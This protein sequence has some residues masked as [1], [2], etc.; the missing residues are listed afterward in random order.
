MRA[1]RLVSMLMILQARGRLTAQELAR[2]LEVSERT[3]YRDITAL[4]TAGVPIYAERGPGGGIALVERYR[5]NLTGLNKDEVQ[6][7]FMLSVPTAL[8]DLGLD[9]DLKTALRKLAA[10]LPDS[11]RPD[12]RLA[13]QQVYIDPQPWEQASPGSSLPHLQNIQQ[14]LQTSRVIFVRYT[15]VLSPWVGVLEGELHPYGMVA[16]GGRW[17]IIGYLRDHIDVL[18]LDHLLEVR[19]TEMPAQRPDNFNLITF[20]EA[21]CRATAENRPSFPVRVR[22]SPASLSYLPH[23]LGTEMPSQPFDAGEPDVDGWITLELNFEYH[24]QALERLLAFGGS[25]EVLEPLALRYSIRDYAEQILAVYSP[26][27]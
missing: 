5:S 7:L 8:S 22:V 15:S 11:L 20:W 18:R 12:E 9:Q 19:I 21:W 6:A 17:Y 14:A 23:L 13:R 26:L 4:S 24:E 2:E 1:D 16:K 3:I 10:A 25:I 27:D